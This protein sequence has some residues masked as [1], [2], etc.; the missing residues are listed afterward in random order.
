MINLRILHT[1]QRSLLGIREGAAALERKRHGAF[2]SRFSSAYIL[3]QHLNASGARRT[4]VGKISFANIYNRRTI[5]R[6]ARQ[7]SAVLRPGKGVG[8][9]LLGTG[10]G[11]ALDA[12]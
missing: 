1:T 6:L 2:L 7:E 9:G 8:F 11:A 10:H 5:D 3:Q 12:P 4:Y